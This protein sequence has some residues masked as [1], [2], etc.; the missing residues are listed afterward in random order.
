MRISDRYIGPACL[1]ACRPE[2]APAYSFSAAQLPGFAVDEVEPLMRRL[3]MTSLVKDISRL[4]RV[5]GGPASRDPDRLAALPA[6]L[7]QIAASANALKQT[8]EVQDGSSTGI[9]E[10]QQPSA[11]SAALAPPSNVDATGSSL[12]SGAALSSGA[13]THQHSLA[14]NVLASLPRV[15]LVS[16][17]AAL[18][19]L[20]DTLQ[21]QQV[22]QAGLEQQVLGL[23]LSHTCMSS[24]PFPLSL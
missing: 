24:G 23:L 12:N 4:Q 8:D 20:V 7:D 3:Q 10:Q 14:D 6:A 15:S 5:L 16:T 22:R 18:Q 9:R 13:S 17:Q 19:D 21:Q 1:P 2:A 11:P